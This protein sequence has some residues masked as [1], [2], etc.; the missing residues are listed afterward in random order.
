[1]QRAQQNELEA[2]TDMF[3]KCARRF[4]PA[5]PLAATRARLRALVRSA[6]TARAAAIARHAG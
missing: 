3:N 2:I 6:L 5:P 4:Q 1:M